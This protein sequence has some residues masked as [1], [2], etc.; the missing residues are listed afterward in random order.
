MMNDLFLPRFIVHRRFILH[1]IQVLPHFLGIY[2]IKN[3]Q[4][5]TS[6]SGG[7]PPAPPDTLCGAGADTHTVTAQ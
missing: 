6:P 2:I 5:R 7:L 1:E 4:G 3:F